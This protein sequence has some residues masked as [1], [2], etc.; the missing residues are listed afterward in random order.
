MLMD[1]RKAKKNEGDDNYMKKVL[2]FLGENLIFITE[3]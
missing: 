1:M 3:K 2:V